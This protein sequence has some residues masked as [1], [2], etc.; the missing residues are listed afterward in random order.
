MA[1]SSV[2]FM[3]MAF[4]LPNKVG[5]GNGLVT[6]RKISL[7]ESMM[8]KVYVATRAEWHKYMLSSPQRVTQACFDKS[9]T[10]ESY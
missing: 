1:I 9:L 6:W 8:T 10:T 7:P 3:W 5:S 2:A 4:G